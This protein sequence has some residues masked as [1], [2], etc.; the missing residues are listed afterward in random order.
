M[1]AKRPVYDTT[2]P[3]ALA[4]EP[5]RS[6]AMDR[7]EQFAADMVERM[8]VELDAA[9]WDAEK[10]APYPKS[11][12]MSREA[13]N[14]ASRRYAF[15]SMITRSTGDGCRRTNDPRPVRMDAERVSKFLAD[16]REQASFQYDAFICKMIGKIGACMSATLS[17][18]HV[19]GYSFL[20]VQ[21][22]GQE[23]ETWKTQ[24]IVNVSK[25]GLPFNQWP[26]RKV[27]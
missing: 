2:H 27:K 9:G 5:L 14:A 17:G 1:T 8:R 16:T 19:W 10:V 18:S 23:P 4:V 3:V 12:G 6:A 21:H 24:Q 22:K 15:V 11:W 25:L 26:S 7:A 20:T 13:Y